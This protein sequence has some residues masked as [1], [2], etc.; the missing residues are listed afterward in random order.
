MISAAYTCPNMCNVGTDHK[1]W[2]GAQCLAYTMLHMPNSWPSQHLM[3]QDTT[4]KLGGSLVFSTTTTGSTSTGSS[5]LVDRMTIDSTGL[6]SFAG[7]VAIP[8][9][10]STLTVMGS[11]LLTTLSTSGNTAIGTSGAQTLTV[12]SVTTLTSTAP[13]TA[14]AP[15]SITAGNALSALGNAVV[16]TNSSNT[17]SVSASSVFAAPVTATAAVSIAPGNAFSAL[18]NTT[19]G[20]SPAN[21]LLVSASSLFA[22][23]ATFSQALQLYGNSSTAASGVSLSF[24][25]QNAGKAV[26]TGFTLGSIL[27]SGYDGSVQGPTAQIQSVL[28]VSMLCSA[29]TRAVSGLCYP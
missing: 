19:I 10:S 1:C 12:N 24:Q 11:T 26:V 25:R 20:S 4:G 21:S 18:G 13:L 9:A 7:S 23:P 5:Q 14:N 8:G 15:V 17:L 22:A 3:L 16:G 2:P 6:A 28:T 27:F 29:S